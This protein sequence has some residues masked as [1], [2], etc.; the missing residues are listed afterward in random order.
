MW[1]AITAAQEDI[2]RSE[3][4]PSTGLFMLPVPW[5]PGELPHKVL[6][7]RIL[8]VKLDKGKVFIDP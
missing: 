5:H 8:Q 2:S 4:S 3:L 7:V 6:R 1:A